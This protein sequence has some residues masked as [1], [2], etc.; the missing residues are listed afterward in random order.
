MFSP[1]VL[2]LAIFV[3]QSFV[4]PWISLIIFILFVIEFLIGFVYFMYFVVGS[5]LF[6]HSLGLMRK[7]SP[8]ELIL[9][10]RYAVARKG[11]VFLVAYW[12]SNALFFIAFLQSFPA[13][14]MNLK[15]PRTIWRWEYTVSIGE[16]KIARRWG[17]YT[18]PNTEDD[19]ITG[20]GILY[21][22]LIESMP[23]FKTLQYPSQDQ[24]LQ[25]VN[26]LA[27]EASNPDFGMNR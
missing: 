1:M 12:G 7:T 11:S 27:D 10:G 24:L 20:E 23:P 3:I 14:K 19:F 15:I 25:I 21:S 9:R 4:P 17:E 18:V 6:L 5:K 13:E 2:L 22:L 16:V 26:T 8:D